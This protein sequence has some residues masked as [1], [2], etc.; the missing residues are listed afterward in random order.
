MEARSCSEFREVTKTW[1]FEQAPRNIGGDFPGGPVLKT[2]SGS[3][4]GVVR[5]LRSH[6]LPWGQKAPNIKQKQCC[7]K[8]NEDFQK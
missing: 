5:K 2:S 7:N 3:A 6:I 8:F 1:S 4:G